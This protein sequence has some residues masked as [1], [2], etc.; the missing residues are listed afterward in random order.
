[1]DEGIIFLIFVLEQ[2]CVA[3]CIIIDSS[4]N[5][6][7]PVACC[8]NLSDLQPVMELIWKRE[9][10]ISHVHCFLLVMEAQLKEVAER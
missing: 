9:Q 4:V 3:F 1:M 10:K 8:R 6:L 7:Y 5:G 2:C